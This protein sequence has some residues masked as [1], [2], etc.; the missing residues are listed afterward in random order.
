MQNLQIPDTAETKIILK[1][2]L[3]PHFSDKTGLPPSRPDAVLVAPISAEQK[4]NR[5]ATEGGGFL[6]VAAGN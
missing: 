5:L 3:P 4:S 6:G 1:W 2:I